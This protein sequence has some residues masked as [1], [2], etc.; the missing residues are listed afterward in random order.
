M[1][2]ELPNDRAFAIFDSAFHLYCIFLYDT[3]KEMYKEWICSN[4]R[5]K[6]LNGNHKLFELPYK[7]RRNVSRTCIC[8]RSA[9][10]RNYPWSVEYYLIEIHSLTSLYLFYY[11]G[12]A[13]LFKKQLRAPIELIKHL[14]KIGNRVLFVII[15]IRPF[16]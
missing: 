4:N 9:I 13:C 1:P 12:T 2:L 8:P 5:E 7:I 15:Y 10:N 3:L 6:K 16:H 14:F 11:V